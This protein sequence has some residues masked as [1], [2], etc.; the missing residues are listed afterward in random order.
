LISLGALLAAGLATKAFFIPI[1]IAVLVLMLLLRN[2]IAAAS[3]LGLSLP[4]WVFYLRNAAITG[5]LTGLPETIEAK[6]SI[7]SS[8]AAATQVDWIGVVR[9]TAASHIWTGFWS[10]LQFRSWMYAVVFYA[11]LAGAAGFALWLMRPDSRAG[12]ALAAV[13]VFFWIAL[14]YYATQT[15]QSTSQA[16][17][18]GWYL[19]PFIAFEVFIFVAGA[20]RL[21]GEK[22][23]P[24]LLAFAGV[25][26]LALTI[27]GTCF[28][29]APYYSGL[30]DH[31]PSGHLR[32]YHPSFEHT[33]ILASRIGRLF[34][35]F[36]DSIV[37]WITGSVLI[38]GF[39]LIGT[40]VRS[41]NRCLHESSV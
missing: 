26:L 13:Y 39:A 29:A 41:R 34:P 1:L 35:G 8:I 28:V 33:T 30:T 14:M 2:G 19:T 6:T 27:Y 21:A 31:A 40:G 20:S 7:G 18:Q 15:F 4:G 22:W 36:P 16:I 37:F 32:A 9:A 3:V 23:T 11:F 38:L 12:R 24:A 17:I 10:L 5:S 25:A